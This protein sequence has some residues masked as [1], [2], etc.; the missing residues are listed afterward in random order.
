MKFKKYLVMT[1]AFL[2]FLVLAIEFHSPDS[3]AGRGRFL[4]ASNGCD[5]TNTG[6]SYT[7][8]S[9]LTSPTTFG[10]TISPN[11]KMTLEPGH[12]VGVTTSTG[13]RLQLS[14]G[15]IYIGGYN[16]YDGA[17]A[18]SSGSIAG[19][20]SNLFIQINSKNV[21]LGNSVPDTGN[22]D[23][24]FPEIEYI[25]QT[26]VVDLGPTQ[27]TQTEN[28]TYTGSNASACRGANQKVTGTFDVKQSTSTLS[29]RSSNTLTGQFVG[30]PTNVYT[31]V[32]QQSATECTCNNWCENG[33][34]SSVASCCNGSP[35]CTQ[36][37]GQPTGVKSCN[38][39]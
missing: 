35:V 23:V 15:P 25:M 13:T 8:N 30:D 34:V 29:F 36:I 14:T 21:N 17:S 24:K 37:V 19:F 38:C 33:P 11:G 18:G 4:A 2:F 28:C 32:Q 39:H 3:K 6:S 9:G 1:F 16:G 12:K 10:E 5:R 26:Q 31:L 20:N 7:I 27:S 22:F